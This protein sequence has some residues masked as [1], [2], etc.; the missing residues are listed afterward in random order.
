MRSLRACP[1]GNYRIKA[2]IPDGWAFS[3]KGSGEAYASL[4][5]VTVDGEAISD[6]FTVSADTTATPGIALASCLHVSGTCWFEPKRWTAC[7]TRRSPVLPG[8]KIELN[9]E[10]NG[11]HYETISGEDGTGRSTGCS[12][13][14]TS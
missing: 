9:G 8:V 10:K 12:R 6:A 1:E 11:L 5:G 13:L 14:P 4:F 3:K 7:L 2:I